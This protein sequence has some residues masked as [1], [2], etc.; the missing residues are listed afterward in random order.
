[1]QRY[2]CKATEIK[3]NWG[4]ITPLKENSKLPATDP[5]EMETHKWYEF[6]IAVLNKSIKELKGVITGLKIEKKLRT[7]RSKVGFHAAFPLGHLT[8]ERKWL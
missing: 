6:K 8:I 4:N 1:M 5:K 7:Q 3:K 2:L